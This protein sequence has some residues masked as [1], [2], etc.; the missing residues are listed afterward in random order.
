MVVKKG[1]ATFVARVDTLQRIADSGEVVPHL[2]QII[3]MAKVEAE[4]IMEAVVEIMEAVDSG[5]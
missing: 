1:S 4:E 3:G 5:K 2:L